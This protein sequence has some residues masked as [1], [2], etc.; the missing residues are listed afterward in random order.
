MDK[1]KRLDTSGQPQRERLSLC[2]FNPNKKHQKRWY[3]KNGKYGGDRQAP[4]HHTAEP[5]IELR[6]RA[7]NQNQGQHADD[8]GHR[9]HVNRSQPGAG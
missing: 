7:G 3:N 5:S 8:T 6:A 1:K 2:L 9:T 4:Q